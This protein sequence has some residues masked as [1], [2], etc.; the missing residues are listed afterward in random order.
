MVE[1][2]MGFWSSRAE[3]FVDND[4]NCALDLKCD[5]RGSARMWCDHVGK[6]ARVGMESE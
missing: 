6:C 1:A 5:L 2:G 4:L 3:G